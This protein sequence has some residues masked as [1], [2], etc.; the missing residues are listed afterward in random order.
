MLTVKGTAG[1]P[2][3]LLSPVCLKPPFLLPQGRG[4][5]GPTQ[6]WMHP[7][8]PVCV[9]DS[10]QP[11]PVFRGDWPEHLRLPL[12]PTHPR[13]CAYLSSVQ[14][15]VGSCP[16]SWATGAIRT[17]SSGNL[18]P[19]PSAH[20]H[21]DFLPTCCTSITYF[22]NKQQKHKNILPP[23]WRHV[24]PNSLVHVDMCKYTHAPSHAQASAH[25]CFLWDS[26][27]EWLR[28]RALPSGGLDKN[29]YSWHR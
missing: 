29:G 4:E 17:V 3:Q 23:G 21:K 8:C 13:L 2:G 19:H 5:E 12:T 26:S 6:S 20:Q 18:P 25:M 16:L 22:V 10:S 9:S 28:G 14:P 11:L 24:S 1:L 27:Q 15:Q 7:C